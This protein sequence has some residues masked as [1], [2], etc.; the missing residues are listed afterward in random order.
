MEVEWAKMTA[1]QLRVLASSP[2][3]MAVLPVGAL[4]QHGPHLPVITDTVEANVA[5]IEA[6]HRVSETTPIAVL[7]PIWLG[8]SENM[9]PFGGTVSADYAAFSGMIRSVAR[10]LG[11][12]GFRR[13]LIVNGH[14]GNMNPLSVIVRE[15]SVE[16]SMA[17]GAA[18]PWLLA[19]EEQGAVLE[20]A[21]SVQHACEAET[22]LMLAIAH[23]L[24]VAEKIAEAS[25]GPGNPFNMPKGFSRAYSYAELAP[26]SGV[27][28]DP[29]SATAEK[30]R[31]LLE[32]Q[33]R[34]LAKLIRDER[35][36]TPPDPVWDRDRGLGSTSK[37]LG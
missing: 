34:E 29:R 12:L 18:T 35:L 37:G 8:M 24:V 27:K 36:W 21:T 22:S 9:L 16:F 1:P 23:D 15:L 6:A 13:L 20:S 19:A 3:A 2:G 30:G 33:A 17:I 10:S 5:A 4:E 7:P 11:A 25:A 32:I 26:T 28:G 14:G 31:A